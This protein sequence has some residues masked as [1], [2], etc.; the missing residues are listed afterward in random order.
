M[1]N[2]KDA[3]T[4]TT[5]D[6]VHKSRASLPD[7]KDQEFWELVNLVDGCTMLSAEKLYNLY[8]CVRYIVAND[9]PGDVVEFGVWR[10]G[11][12]MLAGELLYLLGDERRVFLY[13]TFEGF[14]E[15]S[16]HDINAKGEKIGVHKYNNMRHVVEKNL[17]KTRCRNFHIVEGDVLKTFDGAA[18]DQIAILRLDT[19]T[20]NT[21]IHELRVGY[22]KLSRGG[23]FII[24]DYGYSQG[25]RAATDE[26]FST[27]RPPLLQRPNWS[28]RTAVKISE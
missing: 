26:Y 2:I 23:V 28:S 9:I 17:R 19:D 3:T 18:H 7:V 16:D 13:D 5:S 8:C 6:F 1:S 14:T 27:R 11:A 12:M 20:Y 15:R 25:A 21:T 10:G 4:S 24:D 22:P